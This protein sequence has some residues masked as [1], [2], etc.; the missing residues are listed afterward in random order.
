[1]PIILQLAGLAEES[2]KADGELRLPI[3]MFVLALF[4]SFDGQF[5]LRR[6][7]EYLFG[8]FSAELWT[9][10]KKLE[11][12]KKIC[13]V[14]AL[15]EPADGLGLRSTQADRWFKHLK[16]TIQK[17]LLKAARCS[18]YPLLT[19]SKIEKVREVLGSG[20]DRCPITCCAGDAA[21]AVT[22]IGNNLEHGCPRGGRLHKNCFLDVFRRAPAKVQ[23]HETVAN[24]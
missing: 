10:D 24:K 21:Y 12:F 2:S 13:G 1:M 3:N 11:M 8:E 6:M 4:K 20:R 14:L 23:G 15:G 9:P 7:T 22:C 17:H 5:H 19:E 16:S 18:Y